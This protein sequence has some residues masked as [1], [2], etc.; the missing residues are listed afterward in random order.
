MLTSFGSS[1]HGELRGTFCW[2]ACHQQ[3]Y[4]PTSAVMLATFLPNSGWRWS[5]LPTWLT[6][7]SLSHA[8]ILSSLLSLTLW[9]Y[10]LIWVSSTAGNLEFCTPFAEF[11]HHHGLG[12]QQKGQALREVLTGWDIFPSPSMRPQR[13]VRLLAHPWFLDLCNPSAQPGSQLVKHAQ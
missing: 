1:P 7:M 8:W 11:A 6:H 5:H 12:R 4:M 3:K 9:E 13:T 10:L 2:A